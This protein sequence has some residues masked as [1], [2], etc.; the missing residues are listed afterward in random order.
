VNALTSDVGYVVPIFDHSLD[1]I[2]FN[3][4]LLADFLLGSVA[5]PSDGVEHTIE[6][7][8]ALEASDTIYFRAA[9]D[10]VPVNLAREVSSPE[11]DTPDKKL[12]GFAVFSLIDAQAI[13]PA[14]IPTGTTTS[15]VDVYSMQ[16]ADG[17]LSG[18]II[19]GGSTNQIDAEA[20]D[21]ATDNWLF[22]MLSTTDKSGA[23]VTGPWFGLDVAGATSYTHADP[24]P[25]GAILG[26]R[27]PLGPLAVKNAE[28]RAKVGGGTLR[29]YPKPEKTTLYGDSVDHLAPLGTMSIPGSARPDYSGYPSNGYIQIEGKSGGSNFDTLAL[30]GIV[31]FPMD[32]GADRW[33]QVVAS[34]DGLSEQVLW[35]IGVTRYGYCYAAL[36]STDGSTFLGFADVVGRL[37]LHE[38]DNQLI[39]FAERQDTEGRWVAD[40]STLKF[41]LATRIVDRW[42]L[43]PTPVL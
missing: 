10:G 39:I 13:L 15:V 32:G 43:G 5:L 2:S 6:L 14:T 21:N 33:A 31:L 26:M 42:H 20:I 18:A 19:A 36:W 24:I 34:A 16:L 23:T 30:K 41:Q 7:T 4:S 37:A 25:A 9:I 3:G 38:G 29:L 17:I 28:I 40:L 12:T 11:G 22:W 27:P 35:K 8:A 1:E